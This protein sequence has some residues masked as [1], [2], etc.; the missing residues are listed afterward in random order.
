VQNKTDCAAFLKN[1]S[2]YS[3]F[4]LNIYSELAGPFAYMLSHLA[5][6]VFKKL[7]NNV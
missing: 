2:K 5:T 1:L 3:F 7:M 4:F 6:Q